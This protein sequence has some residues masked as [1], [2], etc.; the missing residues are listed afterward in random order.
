MFRPDDPLAPRDPVFDEPWQAQALAIAD[1]M[2]QAG[3]FSASDWAEYF[4]AALHEADAQ[5]RPDTGETYYHCAI[6]ALEQLVAQA[7][8]IDTSTLSERKATW[9]RAYLAT[10]HGQP[11]KL[12]A[13]KL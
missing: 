3:H 6:D 1:A 9:K 13:G 7:T 5:G 12:A 2:V 11:V 4:G 8:S 10:P